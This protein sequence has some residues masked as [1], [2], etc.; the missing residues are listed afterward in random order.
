[1][2]STSSITKEI[3]KRV[4]GAVT[5]TITKDAVRE[6]PVIY[7]PLELQNKF[8]Q[9]VEKVEAQKQ[10][11]EQVIEQMNNLF[12]SLSPKAFKGEL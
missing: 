11:N 7:P 6:I 2:L 1:M 12:N 4:K 10:K 5:K 8:A 9:I 3:Q